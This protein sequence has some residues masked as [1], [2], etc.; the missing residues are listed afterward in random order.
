MK[1]MAIGLG[2]QYGASVC[3]GEGFQQMAYNVQAFGSAILKHAN[4]LCGV[5]IIENAFDETKKTGRRHCLLIQKGILPTV[6]RDSGGRGICGKEK[7]EILVVFIKK[8]G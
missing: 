1:M 3:H 5:G 8:M 6:F 2:K 7:R 4:I